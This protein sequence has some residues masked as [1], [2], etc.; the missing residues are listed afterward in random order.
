MRRLTLIVGLIQAANA[1]DC[2]DFVTSSNIEFGGDDLKVVRISRGQAECE[3]E[4]RKLTECNAYSMTKRGSQKCF[5]KRSSGQATVDPFY[6]SGTKSSVLDLRGNVFD[7]NYC[8]Q[9]QQSRL[10]S[11]APSCQKNCPL[12]YKTD[13]HG[14]VAS[15]DCKSLDHGETVLLGDIMI[16][17]DTVSKVL[18]ADPH[19]MHG[20]DITVPRWDNIKSGGKYHIPYTYN[21]LPSGAHTSLFQGIRALE[22]GTCLKFVQ[23]SNQRDYIDFFV[24][25]GCYSQVG[26][27][28]GRQEISL[29]NGCWYSHTVSHE[30]MHAL[31][32]WHEQMRP[33]RDQHVYVNF[34]NISPAMRYNFNKMNPSSWKSFGQEYDIK[35]VMQYH[36]TAFSSNGQPT[37][38]DRSTNR[39]IP[40]NTRI[41]Q[42]DFDQLNRLYPCG[43]TPTPAPTNKPTPR[44]TNKPTPRPTQPTPKPTQPTGNCADY[45]QYCASWASTGE[46]SKNPAYMNQYCRKSCRLCGSGGGGGGGS[47][48]NASPHCNYWSQ[49]GYCRSNYAYMSQSCRKA[50]RLC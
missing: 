38:I 21:R 3:E 43:S 37:M 49:H 44:P 5:L 31:G 9:M 25:G 14:C 47:C 40:W 36:G 46:C 26:R 18:P 23:R 22:A 15:C 39:P 33:D 7:V 28:G 20:V 19:A 48:T 10:C 34:N 12:G 27:R 45:N 32:F 4:C 35:S 8:R 42:N 6:L 17:E 50:C 2:I 1:I 29:G 13:V 11:S 30:I 24:G 41:T 16:T